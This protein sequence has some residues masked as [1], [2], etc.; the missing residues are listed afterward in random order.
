M[1]CDKLDRRLAGLAK[2][3]GLKYS[4]Y[5]DDITF[6]SMHN[7]YQPDSEFI[8][9][10]KRIIEDQGFVMTEKITRLQKLGSRQEVTGIIVSEKLIIVSEKL[11]VTQKYVHDIRNILYIWDRYGFDDAYNKFFPKY[12]A[13]KGH[14]KKE[15][16]T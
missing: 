11:N 13:D 4:R 2:R 8:I 9:E 16:L 14:V 10:L 15:I 3:F 7:V 5:A 6:S 12:N 1:V